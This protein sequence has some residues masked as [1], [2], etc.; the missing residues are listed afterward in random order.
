MVW[1]WRGYLSAARCR[2]AYGP[3]DATATHSLASVKSRL[4]LPFWYRPT[5]VVLDKGPLN[6]C[7]CACACVCVRVCV[8]SILAKKQS[9][10]FRKNEITH[11]KFKILPM[12]H[13][14]PCYNKCSYSCACALHT[15]S[16]IAAVHETRCYCSCSAY[17]LYTATNAVINRTET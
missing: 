7:V 17:P 9:S 16:V 12:A 1:C 6:G 14:M 10:N 5:R 11:L 3:A 4:V 15:L 13:Q 8:C 2:L